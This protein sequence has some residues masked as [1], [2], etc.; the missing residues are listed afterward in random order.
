MGHLPSGEYWGSKIPRLEK[1]GKRQRLDLRSVKLYADG[2]D[3][4]WPFHRG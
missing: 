3:I 1:Y 2:E 4:R